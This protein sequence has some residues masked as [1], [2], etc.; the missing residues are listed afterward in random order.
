MILVGPRNNGGDGLVVAEALRAA[1]LRAVTFW[2]Y[3]RADTTGAPVA[4]ISWSRPPLSAL[5][6][7]G[8]MR[9]YARRSPRPI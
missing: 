1:G 4:A 5:G 6:R 8:Q 9:R 7:P 2:L 3:E